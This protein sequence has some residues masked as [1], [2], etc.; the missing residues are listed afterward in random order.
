VGKP[1]G[2]RVH[3]EGPDADGR[4]TLK[5]IFRK[6]DGGM[7]W[8]DLAKKRGAC[9]ALVNAVMNIRV[10]QNTGNFLTSGEPVN[11]S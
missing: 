1:G 4:I 3:L 9:R 7:N 11:F 10:L 5:W 6:W 2:K 8:I